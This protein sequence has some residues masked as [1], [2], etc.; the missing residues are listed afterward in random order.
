MLYHS[1][2][3]LSY[4]L[5]AFSTAIYLINRVPS[6][7]LNFI[8]PWEK[9]YD[10]KPPLHALKTFG[11][12]CYPFLKPYNSH[13]FDPKSRQ[14]IFLGYPPQSQGYICL[15]AFI[16][17]IYFS[18]H[19]VFDESISPIY[20]ISNSESSILVFATPSPSFDV[21]LSSLIPRFTLVLSNSISNTHSS[22]T[23]SDSNPSSIPVLSHDTLPVQYVLFVSNLV[24]SPIVGSTESISGSISNPTSSN[25]ELVALSTNTR[26]MLTRS[27]NGIF[28]PKAFAV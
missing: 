17:R 28:K 6:S 12:A 23:P 10:H 2:L 20:P 15:V 14:C 25:Q 5:Y 21:W 3:S 4:C 24:V 1:N 9:L 27:K 8:S 13:K 22:S 16:G 19:C 11:C 7:V 26:P 18:R